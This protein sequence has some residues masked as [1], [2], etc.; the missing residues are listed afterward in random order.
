MKTLSLLELM[1]LIRLIGDDLDRLERRKERCRRYISRGEDKHKEL[2][3]TEAEYDALLSV[4][5]KIN[6]ELALRDL[7]ADKN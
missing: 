2:A 6:A 3:L 5:Q 4:K 7:T 1:F